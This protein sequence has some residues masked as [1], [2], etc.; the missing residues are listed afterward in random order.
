MALQVLREVA[1][2][3][4]STP[5]YCLSCENETDLPSTQPVK[6]YDVNSCMVLGY[7]GFGA[8][9]HMFLLSWICLP[10]CL[11]MLAYTDLKFTQLLWMKLGWVS[12]CSL[13]TLNTSPG[14]WWSRWACRCSGERRWRVVKARILFTLLLFLHYFRGNWLPLL[15]LASTVKPVNTGLIPN[16]WWIYGVKAKAWFTMWYK[17]W[18]VSKGNGSRRDFTVIFRIC[19]RTWTS[20]H[21][22]VQW[23]RQCIVSRSVRSKA[24][25]RGCWSYKKECVWHFRKEWELHLEI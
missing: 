17:L 6:L 21:F 23:W 16:K 25:R 19:W 4:H 15:Y 7:R 24:V 1:D 11:K 13:G 22:T 3:L 5:L 8:S 14:N 10:L 12:A 2:N 9:H 18:K 20:I